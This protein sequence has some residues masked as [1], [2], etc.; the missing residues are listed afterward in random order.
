MLCFRDEAG[1]VVMTDPT[2]TDPV[3]CPRPSERRWLGE[4]VRKLEL[5][6]VARLFLPTVARSIV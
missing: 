4:S 2:D 3:S 1:G 5:D 6:G